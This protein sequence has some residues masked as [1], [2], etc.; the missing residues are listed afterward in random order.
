MHIDKDYNK[1]SFHKKR[2][3]GKAKNV[4][5]LFIFY[6]NTLCITSKNNQRITTFFALAQT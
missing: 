5:C 3:E 1:V 2:T 6:R 4:S